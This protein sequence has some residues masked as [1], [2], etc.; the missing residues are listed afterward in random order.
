MDQLEKFIIENRASFDREVPPP[1]V[2][3][4]IE[5]ALEA[6]KPQA[7]V[8]PLWR[9][10]SAAAAAILLL[11]LGSVI[12]VYVYKSTYVREAPTLASLAPE[13]A[14]TESYYASQVDNRMRQL[15][16]LNQETTVESDIQQLDEIYAELQRE[17]DTAPRES[18]D[19]IIQ[20]MIRNYQIKLDI[21]ERVLEKVQTTQTKTSS[22][23]TSI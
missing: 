14:E 8:R 1:Q 16:Q 9:A 10:L 18:R 5:G 7:H 13:F 20:A 22:H 17:L 21:L 11:G 12:G 19:K 2:W 23:E 3:A 4:G 6:R 15:S